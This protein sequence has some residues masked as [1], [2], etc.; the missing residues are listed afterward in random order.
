M[1]LQYVLVLLLEEMEEEREVYC[2]ELY[3]WKRGPE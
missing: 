2:K 3:K 1:H